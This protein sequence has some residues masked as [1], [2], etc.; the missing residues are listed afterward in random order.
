MYGTRGR[1]GLITLATDSSVLP[2]HARLMPDGVALYPAP[3]PLPDGEVTPLALDA[4]L[5][6]DA[7]E[8]AAYAL[9][10]VDVDIIVFACTSGSLIHGPGWD[11]SLA[12]RV[13]AAAGV[14]ATTTATS[15]LQ[16]LEAVGA[17]RLTV[18]TPYLPEVNEAEQRF[19]EAAGFEVAAIGGLPRRRDRDIG[20]LSPQDALDAVAR[21]DSPVTDAIFCSCT[22]WHLLDAVADLEALHGKPVVTSNQASAWTALRALDVTTPVT[23]YGRLLEGFAPGPSE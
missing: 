13:E 9:S 7:L 17:R 3:I 1:I 8:R 14:P 15:V 16:A 5:A 18:V 12:Q 6:S 11:T 19:L 22:N 10:Q 21:W 4:M 2:E 23:G 20:L